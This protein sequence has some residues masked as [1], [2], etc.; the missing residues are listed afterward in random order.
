M[1]DSLS[2]CH[3]RIERHQRTAFVI[4]DLYYDALE[5]RPMKIGELIGLNDKWIGDLDK[6]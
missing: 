3:H 4:A 2:Y 1:E 6:V 5:N